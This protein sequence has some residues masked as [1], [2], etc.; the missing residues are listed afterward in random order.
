[1]PETQPLSPRPPQHVSFQ[2]ALTTQQLQQQG[3]ESQRAQGG[4][5]IANL[6][7]LLCPLLLCSS[8]ACRSDGSV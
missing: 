2:G 5:D 4:K 7:R 1:M 8:G 3:V 6:Y